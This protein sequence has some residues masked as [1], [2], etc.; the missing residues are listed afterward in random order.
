MFVN[1]ITIDPL[2]VKLLF[3]LNF[4]H[5]FYL[6]FT[7]CIAFFSMIC[8][9]YKTGSDLARCICHSQYRITMPNTAYL[10]EGHDIW[11]LVGMVLFTLIVTLNLDTF[12]CFRVEW[13]ISRRVQ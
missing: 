4:P 1:C 6:T 13:D 9:S 7:S 8:N 10:K 11:W 2:L 12:S 3:Q 5:T